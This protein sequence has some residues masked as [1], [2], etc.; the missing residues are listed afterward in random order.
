[1][2]KKRVF[3]IRIFKCPDCGKIL[4]ASKSKGFSENGHKKDIYCPW[5]ETVKTMEQIEFD[6]CK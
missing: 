6:R 1:M 2:K 4:S 3:Y 5:C